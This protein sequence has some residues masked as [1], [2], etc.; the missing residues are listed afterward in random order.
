M[1]CCKAMNVSRTIKGTVLERAWL[2]FWKR[3]T[4]CLA[5]RPLSVPK[6]MNDRKLRSAGS[7]SVMSLSYRGS[8]RGGPS[9]TSN[10]KDI[11]K[12]PGQPAELIARNTLNATPMCYDAGANQLVIPMNPNTGLAFVPLK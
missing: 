10:P 6:T 8:G 2:C 12:H 5:G 9:S 7:L 1:S 11:V 3:V 4:L